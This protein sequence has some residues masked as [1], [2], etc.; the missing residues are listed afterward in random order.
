MAAAQATLVGELQKELLRI[1][2][3]NPRY[4]LRSFSRRL[5]MPV[6]ALSEVLRC[7]RAISPAVGQRILSRLGLDAEVSRGILRGLTTSARASSAARRELSDDEFRVIADWSCFAILS[8]LEA[9]QPLRGLEV[10]FAKRLRLSVR[11]VRDDLTRLERL[12]LVERRGE[13][14]VRIVEPLTTTHDVPSE[15]LRESHDQ[16]L[17]LARRAM[18]EQISSERDITGITMLI[19]PSRLPRAKERL[20]KFRR[21]L[22][23]FLESGTRSRVYRLN[24]QL[25]AL[26]DIPTKTKE[27]K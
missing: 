27:K 22:C 14:L 5:G 23:A 18:R 20:R 11:R 12:G 7:K 17:G 3:K 4:S 9:D 16:H 19:D 13:L 25:F 2:Q 21:E 15:A 26:S 8:L 24:L 6:S 10:S 1:R